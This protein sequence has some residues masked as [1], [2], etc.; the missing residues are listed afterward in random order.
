MNSSSNV[1]MH[2]QHI[3]PVTSHFGSVLPCSN[4]FDDNVLTVPCSSMI[5]S[6]CAPPLYST[7]LFYDSTGIAMTAV[8]S[9]SS[10]NTINIGLGSRSSEW[11]DFH[12]V[13]PS[14]DY[15]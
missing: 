9:S 4:Q 14:R 15:L 10:A 5:S 6:I 7:T 3:S 2:Q 11:E 1:F 12:T 8:P 13:P